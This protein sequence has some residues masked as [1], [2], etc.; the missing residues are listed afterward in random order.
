MPLVVPHQ[1][2]APPLRDGGQNPRKCKLEA[3]E[4]ENEKEKEKEKPA[5]CEKKGKDPMAP[6]KALI[7]HDALLSNYEKSEVLEH[8]LL[9]YFG[10]P[11]KIPAP[12]RQG[13]NHGYDDDRGDYKVIPKDH[14]FFRFEVLSL[15]GKGSFGQVLKCID[16]RTGNLVAV[17]IIRNKRKFH[18]QAMVE[19]KLLQHLK[20]RDKEQVNNI[21]QM[22]EYFLFRNHICMVFD[23][24]SINIYEFIKANKFQALN[25]NLVRRFTTQLL[26]AF[27]Y[28]S[29][30][31][32]IH[33][34]LKPEN[35]LLKQHNRA[36]IKVIDFGSSCFEHER[37][38]TYMQSRFYRA[39]EVILGLPYGRPIDMWSIGCTVAELATGHP[40]FPGENETEQLACIMEVLGAPPA[41]IVQKS[42]RRKQFFD[43]SGAPRIIPNSRGKKRKPGD[44]KLKDALR[45]T[46]PLFT[47]FIKSCLHWSPEYR[48]TPDQGLLHP[49]I[50]DQM[51]PAPPATIVPAQRSRP[52][53]YLPAIR[54]NGTIERK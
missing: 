19:I 38:Y 43:T 16:H 49:W 20:A 27:S 11:N 31:K 36:T 30:E 33:C 5:T 37:L 34:D 22:H 15:L 13:V 44:R 23:L 54:G 10:T 7:V 50:M 26:K 21:V 6:A 25:P 47:D 14:L 42:P 12:V 29:R 53:P 18:K 35:I 24:H 48:L 51:A 1:P 46:D 2:T 9:Y 8:N 40:L 45:S 52:E 17:K 39:P 32:I 28:L 41:K 4:K 3:N